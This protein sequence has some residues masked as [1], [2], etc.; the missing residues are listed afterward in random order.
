[1][2][3]DYFSVLNADLPGDH[4][5][6][7]AP[8][9]QDGALIEPPPPAPPPGILSRT[10]RALG[11]IAGEIAHP[12]PAT[13]PEGGPGVGRQLAEGTLRGFSDVLETPT[14][15]GLQGAQAIG[16]VSPETVDKITKPMDERREQFQ[17]DYGDSTAASVGRFTGQTLAT[18][19]VLGGAGRAISAGVDAVA[20]ALSPVVS[21][22][23]G[24]A[25]LS[26]EASIL[27]RAPVRAA[28]LGSQGA[29][30]GAATGA[31]TAAPGETEQRTLEGAKVGGA[32]GGALGTLGTALERPIGNLTGWGRGL[33]ERATADLADKAKG[34]GIDIDPSQLT[35]NW[36]YRIM[37]DQA[38]KLPLSG[39]D[40][41]KGRLQWQDA[42]AQTVGE[43][44]P[45]GITPKIM[46]DAAKRITGVFDTVTNKT[47]V[48]P[49]PN[50]ELFADLGKIGTD[51]PIYG[52]G[53][54][55]M[56]PIQ[57]AAR[58]I[59]K[60]FTDGGGTITGKAYQNLTQTGGPLDSVANSSDRTVA[61]FGE[62]LRD[63]LKGAFDRSV[64]PEDQ[65]AYR[66]AQQQYRN[67]KT[68]QPL[69]ERS[70]ATPYGINPDTLLQQARVQ[71]RRF[72]PSTGGIAYDDNRP[73]TDL[74]NIGRTFFPH[75]PE[76]G[77]TPR[78]AV[79]QIAKEGAKLLAAPLT[80]GAGVASLLGYLNPAVPMAAGGILGGNNLLQRY[81]HSP[82]IGRRM[83][84]QSLN[85]V[86]PPARG[87]PPGLTVP[88]VRGLL[89]G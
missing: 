3:D 57:A 55:Q 42:L 40:P 71:S 41:M 35:K 10:W 19:P 14:R 1:M 29:I 53:E 6:P 86:T 64:A 78:A 25:R 15:W 22:L 68:I 85:P 39:V 65:A 49:G 20:P 4:V 88:L 38:G 36:T 87:I 63:A 11:D 44:A 5:A 30:Q 80:G 12:T 24:G 23:G 16:A 43:R 31:L 18:A 58:N 83:V 9:F 17:K 79:M 13:A 77:T 45:G 8:G 26:P 66:L 28:S 48:H 70:G 82:E 47:T 60:A 69:V 34:Y 72:D 52:L 51:M 32:L 27:L 84:Q 37:G 73:L 2:A 7:K 61:L 33:V 50:D 76:S 56:K 46:D 81:L 62:R 59:I 75:I 67:L 89:G 74:A 54:P 21:F